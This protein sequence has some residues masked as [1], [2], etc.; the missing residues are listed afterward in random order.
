M[1]TYNGDKTEGVYTLSEFL[2]ACEGN[3]V[4]PK[5]QK[6]LDQHRAR[7]DD[8]WLGIKDEV[9]PGE[10]S[11]Q[12]TCRLIRDGW[13]NG[14]DL[15]QEVASQIDLPTPRAVRRTQRWMAQGDDVDM[16]QIWNG[17]LDRAWR[18]TQRDYR[19]G[20][21]RIRLLIDAIDSGGVEAK[22]MRW[23][24]VA[25]L[26]LADALTEAGYSVQIESA[27]HAPDSSDEK[28]RF[29]ARI[30]VKEYTQPVD[31]L[32]LA[33]TSAL[34]AFFRSLIHTWGAVV[35]KHERTFGVS[36]NVPRTLPLEPFKDEGDNAPAFILGKQITS[37]EKASERIAEIVKEIDGEGE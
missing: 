23:R 5:N 10:T 29:T 14:V 2:A 27:I 35:A 12:T 24:G 18:G 3:A 21:Q 13:R 31:L 37:A 26:K 19:N 22:D 8:S 7:K 6:A 1:L 4:N 20:P 34:P 25:A 30:I 33:A 17:N 9:Q 11:H 16:Q 32:T 36:Y 15:M 28:K